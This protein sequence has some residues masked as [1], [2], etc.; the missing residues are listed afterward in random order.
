MIN[1]STHR[2]NVIRKMTSYMFL[3]H[4][5]SSQFEIVILAD[6]KD[7]WN[8]VNLNK[9]RVEL[10]HDEY[11]VMLNIVR[12]LDSMV[13]NE[14]FIDFTTYKYESIQLLASY[15]ENVCSIF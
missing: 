11:Y 3:Q 1:I 15:L 8:L 12:L 13:G 5:I 4:I 10:F 14:P 2:G 6:A 7:A 9:N